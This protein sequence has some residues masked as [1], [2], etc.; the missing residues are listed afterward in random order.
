MRSPTAVPPERQRRHAVGAVL[1]CRCRKVLI[2][3]KTMSTR[4][5]RGGLL[6]ATVSEHEAE[7]SAALQEAIREQRDDVDFVDPERQ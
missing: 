5:G 1:F 7:R 3:T 4:R 2:P 6:A